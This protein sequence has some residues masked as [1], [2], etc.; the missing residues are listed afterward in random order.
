VLYEMFFGSLRCYLRFIGDITQ[1]LVAD[2]QERSSKSDDS[3]NEVA[4]CKAHRAIQAKG[5][6]L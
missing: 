5:Q 6:I 4:Y 2:H 1:H 3:R